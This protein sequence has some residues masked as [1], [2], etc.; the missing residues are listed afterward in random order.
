MKRKVGVFNTREDAIEAIRRLKDLGYTSEE[1]SIVSKDEQMKD[2]VEREHLEEVAG[3]ATATGAVT[4]GIV[5]GIGALLIELGLIAIP[6]IGPWLAVGPVGAALVGALT[7]GAVGGIVGA[8]VDM[9]FDKDEAEA[10]D[11]HI[12]EG[13]IL[14][15]VDEH[16]DRN[17][18]IEQIF[19]P[20]R[21][22]YSNERDDY[23]GRQVHETYNNPNSRDERYYDDA[24]AGKWDQLKGNVQKQWGKLTN[25][26]LDVIKGDRNILKGKLKEYY[27]WNDN[28]VN[29]EFDRYFQAENAYYDNVNTD[30]NWEAD[31]F[32]AGKWD[33][34]KGNVQKQWGKLTDDDLDVIK[35][36]KNILKGKLKEHYG[37]TD[38]DVDLQ[39]DEYYRNER[40]NYDNE[41]RADDYLSGKWDQLKGN[42]QKQWGK[43][44]NDDL[45]VIKGDRNILKGRLKEYYGWNDDEVDY[46]VD[47]YLRK[48]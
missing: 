7:G 23:T 14:V 18:D 19:H 13:K 39:V 28:E 42:I 47:D 34:F 22:V 11:R 35:G 37:W 2:Y 6:G 41:F 9:G 21:T 8:L 17:A 15:M 27:G 36:N 45:D 31:D 10:Y 26:D 25:D 5:G 1:I 43:L 4:G 30:T 24:F 16:V 29:T 48:L 44:T 3:D 32:L 20:E 40:M 12:Q 33:Q 46:Q 38:Q